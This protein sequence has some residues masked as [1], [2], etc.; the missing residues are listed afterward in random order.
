MRCHA[1]AGAQTDIELFYT[2]GKDFWGRGLA[3]EPPKPF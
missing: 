3:T 1:G 2:L